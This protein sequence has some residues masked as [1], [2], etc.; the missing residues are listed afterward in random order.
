MRST[1]A[2]LV[3]FLIVLTRWIETFTGWPEWMVFPLAGIAG[4]LLIDRL[5]LPPGARLDARAWVVNLAL[6]GA[7][8]VVL[9]FLAP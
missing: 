6:S 4:T 3:V 1:P 7:V 2:L 5:V 9:A 8:G